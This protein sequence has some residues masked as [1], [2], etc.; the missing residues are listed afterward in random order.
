MEISKIKPLTRAEAA[1][2]FAAKNKGLLDAI[3]S[4][5]KISS[6]KK[7]K[8][9]RKI[10]LNTKF[11]DDDILNKQVGT[12]ELTVS[13][14][15]YNPNI[16]LLNREKSEIDRKFA[17]YMR[18]IIPQMQKALLNPLLGI[19]FISTII[20]FNWSLPNLQP[21]F[22]LP[23]IVPPNDDP[24]I[25]S[26]PPEP[27]PVYDNYLNNFRGHHIFTLKSERFF[28]DNC[29]PIEDEDE[30]EEL[31][32]YDIG[33]YNDQKNPAHPYKKYYEPADFDTK[34]LLVAILYRILLQGNFSADI[35]YKIISSYT[36]DPD[37]D[38]LHD[39]VEE[40]EY[41]VF[42]V[43]GVVK[44][45][46]AFIERGEI[47]KAMRYLQA[48]KE[49][50]EEGEERS[51]PTISKKL[52][53][54][55]GTMVELLWYILYTWPVKIPLD[56]RGQTWNEVKQYNTKPG[57]ITCDPGFDTQ[58]YPENNVKLYAGIGTSSKDAN[59][60]VF[61]ESLFP[62]QQA[63]V[64]GQLAP[65]MTL[66]SYADL[67]EALVDAQIVINQY[68]VPE[69]EEQDDEEEGAE[70]VCF[71]DN[72]NPLYPPRPGQQIISRDFVSTAYSF[73]AAAKFCKGLGCRNFCMLE[74]IL[75]PG[76][77]L[78]F[79]GSSANEAEVLLKPGNVYQFIKRYKVRYVRLNRRGD[80]EPMVI[81]VYQFLLINQNNT[82]LYRKPRTQT[83]VQFTSSPDRFDLSK[84]KDWSET[85]NLFI[86]RFCR[87][88][89]IDLIDAMVRSV[90]T[91][92]KPNTSGGSK[93]NR[94]Q[95]LKTKKRNNKRR[96]TKK[97]N[98]KRRT[99]K[100]RR[101]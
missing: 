68:A 6:S 51:D 5:S 11:V 61:V 60:D 19:R 71:H 2:D 82:I 44:R 69:I 52:L 58:L 89:N 40:D 25:F 9:G 70:I 24:P 41:N 36:D 74:F 101:I 12:I 83:S 15:N 94:K 46:T 91:P 16:A 53:K 43:Y 85:I 1:L 87:L 22:T 3:A 57:Y 50:I 17:R 100:R 90:T 59:Y 72:L 48:L 84:H 26:S 39:A 31:N 10:V 20:N 30:D 80:D 21:Y 18:T 33:R 86:I 49:W 75:P 81:F 98:N 88:A 79:V 56:V 65:N 63:V 23:T 45:I 27:R 42:T 29:P 34:C 7:R 37:P 97:R 73:D 47:D 96:K 32:I 38:D 92:S 8:K 13:D 76:A 55:I 62:D 93:S 54:R 95:N 14:N 99:N 64:P 28:P 78:P 35:I 66:K 4:P 77:T 67:Q